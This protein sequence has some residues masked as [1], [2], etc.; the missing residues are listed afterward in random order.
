[1][2]DSSPEDYRARDRRAH[3]VEVAGENAVGALRPFTAIRGRG[4]AADDLSLGDGQGAEA[5]AKVEGHADPRPQV[6]TSC[7]LRL[8]DGAELAADLALV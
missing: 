5:L 3:R 1:M 2:G 7:S 4:V 8:S 6:E